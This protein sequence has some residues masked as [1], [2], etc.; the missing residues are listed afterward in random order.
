MLLCDRHL[1]LSPAIVSTVILDYY[2]LVEG[3]LLIFLQLSVETSDLDFVFR[4]QKDVKYSVLVQ[5]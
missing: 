2:T 5:T 3:A 4:T 1:N